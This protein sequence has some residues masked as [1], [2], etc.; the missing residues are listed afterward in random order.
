[1]RVHP[2]ISV[3]TL[4]ATGQLCFAG[5]VCNYFVKV[6]RWFQELPNLLRDKK[7]F[8]VRRRKSLQKP[9]F[10]TRQKKPTTANRERLEAAFEELLLYMPTVYEGSQRSEKSLAKFPHGA[11]VEMEEEECQPQLAGQVQ[12]ERQLFAAWL[13]EGTHRCGRALLFHASNMQREEMRGAASGD[14]AFDFC[15]RSMYQKD[16]PKSGSPAMGTQDLANFIAWLIEDSQVP[17]DLSKQIQEGAV[18][19]LEARGKTIQ[20]PQ[21]AEQMWVRWFKQRMHGELDAMRL[22][23]DLPEDL[24]T[25]SSLQEGEQKPY[26]AEAEEEA[27][28]LQASLQDQTLQDEDER[29]P[30]EEENARIFLETAEEWDDRLGR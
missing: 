21:D 5:H 25:F 30:A 29:E 15:Y 7:W 18:E 12:V 16:L 1:M 13:D 28:K 17:V 27:R 22:V 3:V 4:L 26:T 2:V 6:F 14:S 8:L 20:T 24:E 11:E 19:D 9:S 10:R 23:L